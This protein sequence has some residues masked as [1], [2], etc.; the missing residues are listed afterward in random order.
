MKNELTFLTELFLHHKLS[1]A[2][3]EFIAQR[4]EEVSNTYNGKSSAPIPHA[5]SNI[6]PPAHMAGQPPSTIAA[7]MRHEEKAQNP[8]PP[9]VIA[10][11]PATAAAMNARNAVIMQAMS[12]K[13][14]PGETKPRKF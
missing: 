2:T 7:M 14:L 6:P 11:T 10:Q 3:R 5:L 8:E 4:I 13:P 12:G 9:A 1:K